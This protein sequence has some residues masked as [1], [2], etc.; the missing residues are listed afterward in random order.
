MRPENI[1]NFD[2]LLLVECLF[3][4]ALLGDRERIIVPDSARALLRLVEI[5]G[6]LSASRHE[7]RSRFGRRCSRLVQLRRLLGERWRCM[8]HSCLSHGGRGLHLPDLRGLCRAGGTARIRLLLSSYLD[9]LLLIVQLCSTL[10]LLFFRR[11][12]CQEALW[13][14]HWHKS[15]ERLLVSAWHSHACRRQGRLRPD[16]LKPRRLENACRGQLVWH[17]L[18][19]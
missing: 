13:R 4:H 15:I 16:R 1:T 11:E 5:V 17:L 6:R 14:R 8:V 18:A 10:F 7:A 12:L 3:D 2:L 19:V 9:S